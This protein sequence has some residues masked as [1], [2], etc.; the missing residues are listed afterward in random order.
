MFVNLLKYS[1]EAFVDVCCL[2]GGSLQKAEAEFSGGRSA[3]CDGDLS[4]VGEIALVPHQ[5]NNDFVVGMVFEFLQ[6][7]L[8]RLEC[9]LLG[10]V[11]DQEGTESAAVVRR[12]DGAIALLAG[13]VPDLGLDDFVGDGDGAGCKLYAD[14]S[15][16]V[17]ID[18]VAREA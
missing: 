10:D 7:A 17:E 8:D 15:L 16:G 5:H 12:G 9:V 2:Q 6:P 14:G 3:F 1:F 13:R 18:F 11:V 4:L